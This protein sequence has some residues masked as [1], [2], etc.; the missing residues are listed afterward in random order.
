MI[1]LSLQG[2]TFPDNWKLADV[3]PRL[4]KTI[5]RTSSIVIYTI[6]R[7]S[8]IVIS[9]RTVLEKIN[10]LKTSKA[11]G[12]DGI[13]PK[14]LKLAG[15]T[16]VPTLVDMYNYY[17]IAQTIVFSSWKTARLSPIFKKDDETVCGNYRPVSLLSVPSKILE[18]EINDR[19]VQHVFKNN[20]LITDKQWLIDA[21]SPLSFY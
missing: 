17:S 12:P 7:T 15:K 5:T 2:E 14:L 6:T 18:A 3:K 8:S 19:L 1:N 21:V 11:T 10:K 16:I 13:S 9:N 20:Q 4:K